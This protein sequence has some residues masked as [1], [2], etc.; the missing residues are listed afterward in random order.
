MRLYL[1]F[2]NT[3]GNTQSNKI[4]VLSV[5]DAIEEGSVASS[6]EVNVLLNTYKIVKTSLLIENQIDDTLLVPCLKGIM[7]QLKNATNADIANV[8]TKLGAKNNYTVTMRMGAMQDPKNY[9]ETNKVSK[10]NYLIT[11]TPDTYTSSTKLYRAT[12]LLHE[13][14]HAYM[15]SVVDD[16]NTYPTNTPFTDFPELF[17]AYV[18]KTR[19]TFNPTFAQHEDMA[20][21]YV[22]AIASALEEYQAN[23]GIPSTLADKQVFLDMA[24]SGLQGTDVFNQ[25]F[26]QGS[27]DRNRID[28][29]IGAEQNGLYYQGQY[30]LGK[31]CN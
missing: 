21:K 24:W 1:I 18:S 28:A 22:D 23:T 15:L 4:F 6:Q 13:I 9:A 27:A 7:A 26:P 10:N 14:I 16:Y 8:I 12:A 30:A 31:P 17:I 11:V 20:N 2:L 19:S 25:K 3:D 5:I 29:R